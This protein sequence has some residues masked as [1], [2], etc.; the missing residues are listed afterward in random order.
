[1]KK[2]IITEKPSVAMEFAKALKINT[3]RMNGYLESD[4]WVITWCVGHLV[5]MSYPEVYDE[6]LR[7]WKLSTLPFI[8]KEWKYEIISSVKNQFEIVQR[9]LQ[10]EDVEVIYNAGDSGR[11]GEY[12][13]RLVFM[14]ANPNP[15]AEMK[16]VWI[17]SENSF[18]G[19]ERKRGYIQQF[20]EYML[21]RRKFDWQV[22]TIED[23]LEKG[24][25]KIIPIKYVITLDADTDLVLNSAFELIG[26]M[27][28]ILNTPILNTEKDLVIG[29]HALI[30]P[31]VGI[32][33]VASRKSIFTKIFAGIGGTDSYTDAI[34]DFYQDN[35]D[36]GIFTGKGIYDLKIF[37][38]ILKDE[39]PENTVLSHD[40]LE[41]CYLR[42]G[43]ASDI[44]LMD[45]YPTSYASF[46]T[47]LHRWIRGDTQILLWL[48][49]KINN[50]K[51]EKK[52][53]PLNI[54]SRYKIFDNLLRSNMEASI[55]LLLIFLTF[56][57]YVK[58]IKI[59]PIVIVSFV[60]VLIPSILEIL[61]R[62]ISKKDGQKKQNTFTPI[63]TNLQ[64]SILRGILSLAC[65]PDKAY[66][67]VNAMCISL[68]RMFKSKKH[69]LEWTTSE[70]AE[71]KA[72]KDLISYYKSMFANIIFG[73]LAIFIGLGYLN[74][75]K[76]ITYFVIGILWLVAPFIMWNIS[77]EIKDYFL[78]YN[79]KVIL[80]MPNLRI[81]S[82]KQSSHIKFM[83]YCNK[84]CNYARKTSKIRKL[85]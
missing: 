59:W 58:N 3:K 46:K 27:G 48:K 47:R 39:I 23:W 8:P 61:N 75:F 79:S 15:K 53:N 40:L 54:L 69:L 77:K 16:R 32:G 57:N 13:Q 55:I 11:E 35:F 7:K 24:N 12:I 9:L 10:R 30:Q 82:D 29:G 78:A 56:L 68:Y 2:L 85:V 37:S 43:F 4:D 60:S 1:M 22:N 19:W 45:G 52:K 62:I 51:G 6:N 70:E 25:N 80:N 66:F 42:C 5:T 83:I 18:L 84:M 33:L 14:M 20:N 81:I 76:S 17:D 49:E 41:G 63:I 50:K 34:S 28:H 73:V 44:M 72:K 67:S 31:R 74:N 38:Q 64:G 65:L 71:K 26:A 21:T 36:E